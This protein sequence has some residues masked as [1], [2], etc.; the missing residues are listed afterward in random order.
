N[1]IND[2]EEDSKLIE[3]ESVTAVVKKLAEKD[4]L[5]QKEAFREKESEFHTH[6]ELLKYEF[7]LSNIKKIEKISEI[8]KVEEE[9][10][11]KMKGGHLPPEKK[12]SNLYQSLNNQKALINLKDIVNSEEIP[13]EIDKIN[14][15]LERLLA[16]ATSAEKFAYQELNKEGAVDKKELELKKTKHLKDKLFVNVGKIEK[17]FQFRTDFYKAAEITSSLENDQLI[18]KYRKIKGI[19]GERAGLIY[20]DDKEKDGYRYDVQSTSRLQAEI[21]NELQ[22]KIDEAREKVNTATPEQISSLLKEL[23]NFNEKWI[24]EGKD[25]SAKKAREGALY[26]KKTRLDQV[27]RELTEKEI[28]SICDDMSDPNKYGS[29]YNRLEELVGDR[30]EALDDEFTDS[31]G[32]SKS[33]LNETKKEL[34]SILKFRADFLEEEIDSSGYA[35]LRRENRDYPFL[36]LSITRQEAEKRVAAEEKLRE[37]VYR[38]EIKDDLEK[39]KSHLKELEDLIPKDESAGD[40]TTPIQYAYRYNKE[41][42]DSK[43]KNLEEAIDNLQRKSFINEIDSSVQKI[44]TSIRGQGVELIEDDNLEE[45]ENWIKNGL[46]V[47]IK[48]LLVKRLEK[49]CQIEPKINYED[50]GITTSIQSNFANVKTLSELAAKGARIANKIVNIRNDQ[51]KNDLENAADILKNLINKEVSE[52]LEELRLDLNNFQ[53]L[54]PIEPT[55]GKSITGRQL[56][57]AEMEAYKENRDEADEKELNLLKK[58]TKLEGKD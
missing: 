31:K 16:R 4:G 29:D 38:P 30:I 15:Q 49:L 56:T 25:D 48:A 51:K 53:D 9:I 2:N 5:N 50:I 21:M 39:L 46:T 11:T 45:V 44:N 42:T 3:I 55:G 41:A 22:T 35:N 33:F 58:I 54:I 20:K 18:D 28:Q 36:V 40:Q 34:E 17:Y 13:T 47:E 52:N 10:G 6:L 26:Q 19:S 14:E 12:V 1:E 8:T 23:L 57:P 37:V 43:R 7:Y 27:L 24:E 32:R